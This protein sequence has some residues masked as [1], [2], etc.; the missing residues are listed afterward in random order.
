[1]SRPDLTFA[2]SQL[3]CHIAEPTREH[4]IE[5]MQAL[6][7]LAGT[8]NYKLR[9]GGVWPLKSVIYSDA[10]FANCTATRR[11][12]TGYVMMLG[13]SPVA[14]ASR[15]QPIVTKST[16]ATEVVAASQATDELMHMTKLLDNLGLSTVPVLLR[17]DNQAPARSLV[18]PIEDG[19]TKYLQIHFHYVGE[20]NAAGDIKVEWVS[21]NQMLADMFT[22][23]LGP[24]KLNVSSNWFEKVSGQFS[25]ALIV[26]D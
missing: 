11:S 14:W 17:Q 13:D 12:I 5:A 20:R 15:R 8:R 9:L 1:V 25:L 10:D 21:T 24:Q 3:A 23:A 18:N 22:T 4:L 19:K 2:A 16:T 6:H 7:Y 26:R